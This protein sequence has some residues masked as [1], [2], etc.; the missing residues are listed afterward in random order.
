MTDEKDDKWKMPE[1]VFRSSTGELPKSLQK[2]ISGY[3]M[4]KDMEDDDGEDDILSVMDQPIEPRVA[5]GADA[6]E[7]E[8]EPD[9]L[10]E[11]PAEPESKLQAEPEPETEST[12]AAAKPLVPA[13][14]RTPAPA[15][16]SAPIRVSAAVKPAEP[17]KAGAGSFVLIFLLIAALAAGLVWA[18]MYFLSHRSGNGSAF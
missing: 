6:N 17:K 16:P 7:L 15:P 4:P 10:I 13:I 9:T 2:T 1:P 3:N 5:D 8:L 14:E 11:S 18:I 12:A